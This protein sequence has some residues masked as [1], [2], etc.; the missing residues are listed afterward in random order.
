MPHSWRLEPPGKLSPSQPRDMEAEVLAPWALFSTWP[1]EL[2]RGNW[3]AWAWIAGPARC[4]GEHWT[5][6]SPLFH[7]VGL[8]TTTPEYQFPTL[9]LP[10]S[11]S[12]LVQT[13]LSHSVMSDSWR[14]HG[15]QPAR[16]LCPWGYSSKNPGVALL[17]TLS[18]QHTLSLTWPHPLISVFMDLVTIPQDVFPNLSFPDFAGWMLDTLDWSDFSK[19]LTSEVAFFLASATPYSAVFSPINPI[20]PLHPCP[21]N[22]L[23]REVWFPLIY[24]LTWASGTCPWYWL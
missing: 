21:P 10:T 14:P 13:C 22:L 16:L 9:S 18:L 12:C 19:G 7:D 1:R 24:T 6:L 5:H 15:L 2:S 23:S 11:P 8:L 4:R 3:E 20:A 17:V